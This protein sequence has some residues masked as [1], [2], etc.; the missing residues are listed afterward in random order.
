MMLE[1]LLLCGM[2]WSQSGQVV[3]PVFRGTQPQRFA[4][5]IAHYHVKMGIADEFVFDLRARRTRSQRLRHTCASVRWSKIELP[6]FNTQWVTLVN[7]FGG[8]RGCGG[9]TPEYWALHESA[10]LR[11][12][13]HR[14]AV[15]SV[16]Q[17]EREVADLMVAYSRWDRR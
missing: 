12:M 14:G 1:T 13:H 15:T 5:A 9:H 16:E 8:L 17:Q 2:L 10:H 6:S 3:T 7:W 4:A 11:L